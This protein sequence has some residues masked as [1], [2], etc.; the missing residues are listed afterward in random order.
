MHVVLHSRHVQDV[1]QHV[2]CEFQQQLNGN[3]C[4][5]PT[6]SRGLHVADF[7]L[8]L[9]LSILVGGAAFFLLRSNAGMRFSLRQKADAVEV[10]LLGVSP[11][12]SW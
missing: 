11:C 4:R 9:I 10:S 5:Y 12:F 7:L 1:V 3:F 2:V 6:Q 8:G